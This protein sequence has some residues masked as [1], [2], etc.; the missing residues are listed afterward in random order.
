MS[1]IIRIEPERF[2]G[3]ITGYLHTLEC[4]DTYWNKTPLTIGE[5]CFC[6]NHPK[7]QNASREK[8]EEKS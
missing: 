1:I 5:N 6:S 8:K 3:M 2:Q 4:Q 7:W